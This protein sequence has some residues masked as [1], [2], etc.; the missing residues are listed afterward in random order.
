MRVLLLAL[1]LAAV[2]C[3]T[4]PVPPPPHLTVFEVGTTVQF[5]VNK[6]P[7]VVIYRHDPNGRQYTAYLN[8]HNIRQEQRVSW[9]E[10]ESKSESK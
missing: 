9:A 10:I 8:A 2:G 1:V 7:A 6:T 5:R 4:P 3:N